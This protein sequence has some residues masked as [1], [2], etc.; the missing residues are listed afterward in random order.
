MPSQR[1]QRVYQ[2]S[3]RILPLDLH[4]RGCLG[5]RPN[6]SSRAPPLRD[7]ARDV[8][9]V[10]LPAVQVMWCCSMSLAGQP[11][12]RAG[13]PL[14]LTRRHRRRRSSQSDHPT[15]ARAP[16]GQTHARHG[17]IQYWQVSWPARPQHRDSSRAITCV[18]DHTH[19]DGTAM[20]TG[21]SN[22]T[23][24]QASGAPTG[25]TTNKSRPSPEHSITP[26]FTPCAFV[27]LQHTQRSREAI[28]LSQEKRGSHAN[29]D[30]HRYL[31]CAAKG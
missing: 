31:G 19:C 11:T 25:I 15:R 4:A 6:H 5:P 14:P 23:E 13:P 8:P 27:L 2:R 20:A 12:T 10:N 9:F 16:G 26:P 28:H 21:T 1:H 24:I 3:R 17:Y 29:R 18:S 7:S 30:S 22:D